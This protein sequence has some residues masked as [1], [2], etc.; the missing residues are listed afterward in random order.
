MKNIIILQR[1]VPHY[2]L[3]LYQRLY[4]LLL[5]DGI[6]LTV[7]YGQECEGTV[8]KSIE[9]DEPWAVR[10]KNKYFIVRGKEVIWQPCLTMNANC[11]LI[12]NKVAN[13]VGNLDPTFAHAMGGIDYGLRANKAGFK[14]F[15]AP[16]YIGTCE[17]NSLEGA[18]NDK[19]LSRYNRFK[20]LIS[21]KSLP[22][23]SWAKL[24]FRHGG[25]KTPTIFYMALYKG[26]V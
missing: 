8:P 7:I 11:V 1:I 4:Q 24:T 20:L 9:I 18:F 3:P 14:T 25:I 13:I 17:N 12:P 21:I 10:I 19:K 2:R 26:L 23:K 22:F 16:G 6:R 15:V 5:D